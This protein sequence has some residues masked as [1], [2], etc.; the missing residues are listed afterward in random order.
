MTSL[1]DSI[2]HM[3][4]HEQSER[5]IYT[6]DKDYRDEV[7]G[8]KTISGKLNLTLPP[9]QECLSDNDEIY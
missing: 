3:S 1:Q 8:S 5:G 2:V 6:Y 7:E 9:H 4:I